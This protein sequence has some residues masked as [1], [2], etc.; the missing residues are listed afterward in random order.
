MIKYCKVNK[1]KDPISHTTIYHLCEKCNIF[2]HGILECGNEYKIN[3]LMI[4]YY[5]KLPKYE[6][7]LFG[8]CVN[9]LNHKTE[10]HICTKC[11]NFLHSSSTCPVNNK[12]CNI[13]CPNC[14]KINK[15]FF[16]S[17]G[18]ENKCVIC[19][20]QAQVF[21]PE[22]GHECLCLNCSKKIDS[23]NYLFKINDEKYLSENNYDLITI[24]NQLKNYPSYI[25]IY[26]DLGSCIIIRRLNSSSKLEGLLIYSDDVY[27]P[28]KIKFNDK[29]I[30]GYCKID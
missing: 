26:G 27:N 2:G 16:N 9:L 11:Y 30:N 8:E 17:Y 18:S 22:C 20:D 1:C 23:N 19:Y 21:L 5:E 24:K 7:C 10:S 13:T 28:N 6:K 25:T 15:F 4:Y 3:N 14:R 12:E 29:F